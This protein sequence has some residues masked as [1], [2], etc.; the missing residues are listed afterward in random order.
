MSQLQV[1][2]QDNAFRPGAALSGT[3]EWHLD[4]PARNIELRLCWFTQG[5]GIPEARV[6]E[7]V[8]VDRPAPDAS[9]SFTFPLPESPLSYLGALSSLFWAVE[10]VVL[11][12]QECAHAAFCLSHTGHPIPLM[13]HPASVTGDQTND[14]TASGLDGED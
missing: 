7:T 9:Q 14:A 1:R 10:L 11:P 6:I 5:L 8:R 12:S 2:L 4:S 13:P 3:A